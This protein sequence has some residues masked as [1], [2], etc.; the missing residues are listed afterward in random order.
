MESWKAISYELFSLG[1]EFG[2]GTSPSWVKSWFSLSNKSNLG[3][4]SKPWKR[5]SLGSEIKTN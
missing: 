3:A 5:L 2:N 4:F 1:V